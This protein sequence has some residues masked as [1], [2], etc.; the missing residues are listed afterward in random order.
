MAKKDK[1]NGIFTGIPQFFGGGTHCHPSK[2]EVGSVSEAPI[3]E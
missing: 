1:Q 2:K 3:K